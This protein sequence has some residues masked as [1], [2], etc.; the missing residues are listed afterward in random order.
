M[1]N[2]G[3][4]AKVHGA[5][6]SDRRR[7]RDARGIDLARGPAGDRYGPWL[8]FVREPS[9]PACRVSASSGTLLSP[10]LSDVVSKE[11]AEASGPVLDAVQVSQV[12]QR[13][14]WRQ[15]EWRSPSTRVAPFRTAA[16]TSRPGCPTSKHCGGGSGLDTKDGWWLRSAPPPHRNIGKAGRSPLWLLASGQSEKFVPSFPL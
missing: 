4:W 13:Q 10:P 15:L 6:S 9:T 12:A 14:R 8:A 2:A 7:T 11:H 3:L 5:I 16:W 1:S